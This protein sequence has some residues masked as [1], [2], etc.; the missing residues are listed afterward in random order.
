MA[1]NIID[2]HNRLRHGEGKKGRIIALDFSTLEEAVDRWMS[3]DP[4]LYPAIRIGTLFARWGEAPDDARSRALLAKVL[5]EEDQE[6][7]RSAEERLREYD[8]ANEQAL[9]NA[10]QKLENQLRDRGVTGSHANE[11][12]IYLTFIRLYEEKP[13]REHNEENRFTKDGFCKWVASL[14]KKVYSENRGR[15]VQYLLEEIAEDTALKQADLLRVKGRT[16]QFHRAVCDDFVISEV[17][18]AVF[19]RYSF[20]SS[21]IDILGVVFETL[22]RRGEKDTRVGQ[23]FTPQ[24]VV[25][26]CAQ[27]VRLT[28]VDKVLDPAVGTGRFLIAA[29]NH[30]LA[31]ATTE[32][33]RSA[34]RKQQLFGTDIDDWIVTI[35]KMNMFIH[36]DGKTTIAQSN[37]LILGDRGKFGGLIKAGV[38]GLVDVVLTNPPLGDTSYVVARDMWASL[39]GRAVNDEESEGFFE[40]LGVVPLREASSPAQRQFENAQK[41]LAKWENRIKDTSA[42]GVSE[43]DKE[44]RRAKKLRDKAVADLAEKSKLVAKGPPRPRIVAG[45]RMKGGALF[46]GAIAAYL[47]GNRSPESG[48]EWQGGRRRGDLEHTRLCPRSQVHSRKVLHQGR[49]ELGTAGIQIPR[50]HRRE[51]LHPLPDQEIRS[52]ARPERAR[53]LRARRACRILIRRE[54]DRL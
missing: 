28:S 41:L 34:I 52:G 42:A 37:G 50:T 8:T 15:F 1:L 30:M 40:S 19:D 5:F 16:D 47:R 7:V 45:E 2:R 20:Y 12:L 25:N 13:Q 51:D 32:A 33:E 27:L 10:M 38:A 3:T 14:G 21:E 22:A 46:L 29:M 23:F 4:K 49:G 44:F 11:T 18:E 6:V 9:R 36:G 53:V 17:L 35:A 39:A 31:A 26:F 43:G 54:V 48:I 24:E